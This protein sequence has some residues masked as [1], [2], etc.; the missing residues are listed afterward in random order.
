MNEKLFKPLNEQIAVVNIKKTIITESEFREATNNIIFNNELTALNTMVNRSIITEEEYKQT[1][2]DIIYNN[3]I[4]SLLE[5]IKNTKEM[6][7]NEASLNSG[8]HLRKKLYKLKHKYDLTRDPLEKEK[9]FQKIDKL[10]RKMEA[11]G[12]KSSLNYAETTE[13]MPEDKKL[14][15]SAEDYFGTTDPVLKAKA[16]QEYIK[17]SDKLA[18]KGKPSQLS[19][20]ERAMA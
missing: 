9:L 16:M 19:S 1:S 8:R 10:Q 12:F 6:P 15:Q 4:D 3:S 2:L 14:A 17:R 13:G 18:K 20:M 11:A 7:L 5:Q